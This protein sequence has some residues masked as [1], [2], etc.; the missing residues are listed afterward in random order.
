MTPGMF[1]RDVTTSFY[2]GS[3][4][5]VVDEAGRGSS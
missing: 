4:R 2:R 3:L 5:C 1:V